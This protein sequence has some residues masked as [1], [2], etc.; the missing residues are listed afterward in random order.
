MIGELMTHLW[1]STFFAVVAGLLTLAFRKNRAQVRYW[2]W[3]SASLKF[4]IPFALLI[5]LGSRLGW[6]PAAQK[7]ATPV[8]SFAVE[9]VAQPFP[10]TISIMPRLELTNR[11]SRDWTPLAIA[12]LWLAGVSVIAI[13]R[14][15]LWLRVRA[16]VRDSVPLSI[17]SAVEIRSAPGL[18]EP[19]VIGL[20]RQTLLLPEGIMERLTPSEMQAVLAHEL[21]HVRRR[22]N[23]L[24]SIHMVVEM[25]FWFHPLVWWIGARLLD[26]RERACDESVLSLGNQPRVYAEAIL[27]VCKL[28]AESP[29][30]CVSGVTGSDIKRRIEAIM[31]NRIGLSLNRAKKLLLACAGVAALAAPVAVGV[32]IAVGRLPAIHAQSPTAVPMPLPL[33][34]QIAQAAP[35]TPPAPASAATPIPAG[36]SVA[37]PIAYRDRRLVAMLFDFGGMTSDDQARLQQYAINFVNDG[38]K[39]ADLVCVM[40]AG[41]PA[42]QVA[43]DFT[44]TKTLLITAIQS[45]SAASATG[46]AVDVNAR[47]ANIET[48]SKMLG[49]LPG[50]K[51]VMYFSSGITQSGADNQ[52]ALLAV[53]NAAK[54]ANVAIYPI[55]ARSTVG[56]AIGA[57]DASGGGRSMAAAVVP[58]GASQE[59]YDRRAAYAQS[60]FGSGNNA[61]SRSYVRYGAPDQ[62]EDRGSGVQ[63]WRYNYLEDFHS[64]AAFEFA[65]KGLSARV[66]WPAPEATFE[67]HFVPAS[68]A[69]LAPLVQ[70]LTQEGG[71]TNAT[72][73]L[74]GL[75][76]GHATIQSY[77]ASPGVAP[78]AD[79][80]FPALLV[81]L[82]PLSGTVDIL[83]QIRTRLDT[84]AAGEVAGNVR[85][86]VQA[87]VGTW[88]AIFTVKPGAYV[89]RVL[90]REALT[91]KLFG[92][93]ID[94][95]VK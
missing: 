71:I 69:Q 32:L 3:L 44:D 6:M 76:G 88:Q 20:W 31:M 1:Q 10:E 61:M 70:P 2:L 73:T 5:G 68:L 30:V 49:A 95:D 12:G 59:E 11:Q 7:I 33:P 29:L 16:A 94:F 17:P 19:G 18:L 21:C 48:A 91:G 82:A 46:G 67:G 55:D 27:N 64:G 40:L 74:A 47:L 28:Y 89:C 8:V 38:L 35:V 37:P 14:L 26:E 15:R 90:V 56:A 22:D 51:A 77:A 80:R 92:E 87:S 86:T 62:I 41:A 93:T 81:P 39:P 36:T 24:A 43:Q 83:G 13:M 60:Q 65:A 4:F 53:I 79:R 25:L 54:T 84:G 45:F 66:I 50:K 9:Y 58:P 57:V 63:I 34:V 75:P 78:A 52:T 72:N 42:V 85:D 23:L